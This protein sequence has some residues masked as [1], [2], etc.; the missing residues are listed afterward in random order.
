[1]LAIA[2]VHK[3][4]DKKR[5]ERLLGVGAHRLLVL[6]TKKR[7]LLSLGAASSRLRVCFWCGLLSNLYPHHAPLT[8][9][10]S[11]FTLTPTLALTLTLTLTLTLNFNPNP[12][13]N[14]HPNLNPDPDPNP[15][16]DPDP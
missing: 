12:H 7:P 11:P 10:L 2:A 16:R 5:S 15:N 8:T 6:A 14:L 13:P 3:V 4:G 1:M 9:H